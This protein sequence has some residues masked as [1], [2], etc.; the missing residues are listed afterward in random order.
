MLIF[1]MIR[2]INLIAN[3]LALVA[4]KSYLVVSYFTHARFFQNGVQKV[5]YRVDVLNLKLDKNL[6]QER[7]PRAVWIFLVKIIFCV[8]GFSQRNHKFHTFDFFKVNENTGV[9]SLVYHQFFDIDILVGRMEWFI[10]L[11]GAPD[12]DVSGFIQLLADWHAFELFQFCEIPL[13]GVG[14]FP[15][16]F[17]VDGFQN[18]INMDVWVW[19]IPN[20]NNAIIIVLEPLLFYLD[21]WEFLEAFVFHFVFFITHV[22]QRLNFFQETKVLMLKIMHTFWIPLQS[23]KNVAKNLVFNIFWVDYFLVFELAEFLA[24]D[25][26]GV[27]MILFPSKMVH[28]QKSFVMEL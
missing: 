24:E 16:F 4:P 1:H 14:D 7:L 19:C 11:T 10:A 25:F 15:N 20:V 3:I 2:L 27:I 18:T 13:A 6:V 21:H 17:V 23:P 5:F 22:Q 9:I 12:A 26:W 8:W 28:E